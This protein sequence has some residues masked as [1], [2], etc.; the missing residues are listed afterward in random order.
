[1]RHF[2]VLIIFPVGSTEG[3]KNTL[4]G[5]LAATVMQEWL[6]RARSSMAPRWVAQRFR[7]SP[8][9]DAGRSSKVCE[10][11][12]TWWVESRRPVCWEHLM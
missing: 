1:M 9:C 6:G 7:R 2:Q 3:A 5:Y 11:N 4:E 12:F 10:C 8:A